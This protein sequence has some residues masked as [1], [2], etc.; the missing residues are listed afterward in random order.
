M[1]KKKINTGRG[2]AG[3]GQGRKPLDVKKETVSV[4]LLPGDVVFL[5]SQGSLSSLVA[6]AVRE[7]IDRQSSLVIPPGGGVQMRIDGGEDIVDARCNIVKSNKKSLSIGK[8]C[9]DY[10]D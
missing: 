9:K 6:Q 10:S 7:F 8:I 1:V 3:R 4:R 5:R 2:G